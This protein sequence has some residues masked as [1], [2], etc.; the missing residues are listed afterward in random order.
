MTKK[1]GLEEGSEARDL[2]GEEWIKGGGLPLTD[3]RKGR[4]GK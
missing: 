4:S 2:V 3:W 1:N